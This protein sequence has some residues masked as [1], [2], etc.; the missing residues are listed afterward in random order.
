M[1]TTETNISEIQFG[2]NC[3]DDIEAY[4]ELVNNGNYNNH[5]TENVNVSI[6]GYHAS[7]YFYFG[8]GD[9]NSDQESLKNED[10]TAD[11]HSTENDRDDREDIGSDKK[12]EPADKETEN[13]FKVTEASHMAMQ[14]ELAAK[15]EHHFQLTQQAYVQSPQMVAQMVVP[16]NFTQ[17]QQ[18]SNLPSIPDISK[19]Q[20][21]SVSGGQQEPAVPVQPV[22]VPQ[23]SIA[24]T[25]PVNIQARPKT[26]SP[27]QLPPVMPPV[28]VDK[29]YN[30][31]PNLTNHHLPHPHHQYTANR[32]I[33]PRR[34]QGPPGLD[35]NRSMANPGQTND[36]RNINKSET[37]DN[38]ENSYVTEQNEVLGEIMDKIQN[39][40]VE[41]KRKA[42]LEE[43]GVGGLTRFI[44]I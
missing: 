22:Q 26:V 28:H 10:A 6:S 23:Q 27:I 21:Q 20:V 33:Q 34:N 29:K 25:V 11:S 5:D 18:I 39:V 3:V 30:P 17:P 38:K 44:T 32:N 16:Q 40:D 9:S 8:D 2:F 4:N 37:Q 13:E 31:R 35:V 14:R 1:A 42:D 19:V 7:N 24:Q 43:L 12:N 36:L 15:L 41:K